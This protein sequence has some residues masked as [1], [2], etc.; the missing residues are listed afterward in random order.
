MSMIKWDPFIYDEQS[1]PRLAKDEKCKRNSSFTSS[2]RKNV[3][4]LVHAM[5]V[6]CVSSHYGFQFDSMSMEGTGNYN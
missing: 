5:Y 1:F 4:S 2:A 3:W 6:A